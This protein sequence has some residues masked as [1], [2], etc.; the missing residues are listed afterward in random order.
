VNSEELI[1]N[2]EEKYRVDLHNHTYLCNHA[3]GEIE[4]Y[5]KKAIELGIDVYGFSEHAP[6]KNFDDGYRLKLEKKGFYEKTI[7][8]LKEKY[9]DDLEILLGYE[10][11]FISGDF[12]LDE[13]MGSKVDY[14]IGSVHYLGDWGFDNPEF[15]SK[16][17]NKDIDKIWEEYFYNIKLMAQSGKFDIVGHLDL[18]KVFKFLPKQDIKL[19]AKDAIKAIKD[20]NMV[21][22]L[23]SAGYRKPIAQPYPSK[24]LIELCFEQNIPITFSSDA[25]NVDQVG[26]KYDEISAL[27]KKVGYN[28]CIVFSQ[29]D[30][31]LVNF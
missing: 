1:V 30:K 6:I 17:K 13:V 19:I 29:R 16:Y 7:L 21:I 24:E 18:I 20:S 8:D 26:Y 25:H 2:I 11:D 10:V 4:D 14:L 3:E 9:K 12:L 5:I 23:N 28:K 31:K 27:A 22:E 15:I